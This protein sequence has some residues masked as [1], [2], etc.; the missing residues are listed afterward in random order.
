[1]TMH[2]AYPDTTIMTTSAIRKPYRVITE[3]T[4]TVEVEG[5]ATWDQVVEHGMTSLGTLE[6]RL[7]EWGI[8]TEGGVTVPSDRGER[9]LS[10]TFVVYVR[11]D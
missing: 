3:S 7:F 11:R 4:V 9:V 8:R 1:M 2:E 10:G 5:T 6:G